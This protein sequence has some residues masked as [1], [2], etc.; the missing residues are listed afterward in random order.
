MRALVGK[1]TEAT[2]VPLSLV[3]VITSGAVWVSNIKAQTEANTSRIQRVESD[4][5]ET[6][7]LLQS[8]DGRLS[9][10]EGQ[11]KYLGKRARGD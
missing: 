5:S 10:M 1:I 11:L 3:A 2:A 7:K 4:Q 6:V 8:I 9:N